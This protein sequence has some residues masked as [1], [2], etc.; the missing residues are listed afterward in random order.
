MDREH[1]LLSRDIAAVDMRFADRLVVQL[2][3][4]AAVRA[5][6]RAERAREGLKTKS[7]P[8]KKHMSW[9]GGQK[10]GSARRSG[11]V[12]VL[13]V[14]SSKV[15]CVIARLKPRERRPAAARPHAPGRR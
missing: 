15:C 8:G 10:D 14:G 3:P 2:T 13:D 1:G 6:R 9:L 5:Q 4:E 11:V 7:K 12:T